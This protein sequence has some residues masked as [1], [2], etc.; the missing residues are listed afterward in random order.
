MLAPNVR[1]M[2]RAIR[3]QP[4]RG[5]PRREFDDGLDKCLA[6][7]LRSGFLRALARREQAAVFAT[8]QRL[9]KRQERRGAYAD[10]DLSDSSSADRAPPVASAARRPRT[11]RFPVAPHRARVDRRAARLRPP[12]R[13]D[14]GHDLARHRL[15]R[16]PRHPPRNGT[17]RAH[18]RPPGADP[19]RAQRRLPP[20]LPRPAVPVPEH[21]PPLTH[22]R[23]GRSSGQRSAGLWPHCRGH[24]TA[25]AG[26]EHRSIRPIRQDQPFWYKRPAGPAGI[27]P[28]IRNTSACPAPSRPGGSG[29]SFLW[30]TC[31]RRNGRITAQH[32]FVIAPLFGRS[33]ASSG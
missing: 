33:V 13:R 19:G 18:L 2:M 4:N 23:P 17:A 9:M 3:E 14:L 28:P 22:W 24:P 31:G 1:A 27:R 10:G 21:G 15:D 25:K 16:H 6:R 32:G 5:F 12:H 8:H 11:F 30:R 7:P 29:I 20:G 26:L